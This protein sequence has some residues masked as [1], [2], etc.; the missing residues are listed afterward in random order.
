MEWGPLLGPRVADKNLVYLSI[1]TILPSKYE[2]RD[3]CCTKFKGLL[4][5]IDSYP[6]SQESY[7]EL[8]HV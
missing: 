6:D 5:L 8:S 2:R 1:L 4:S 7:L 3:I